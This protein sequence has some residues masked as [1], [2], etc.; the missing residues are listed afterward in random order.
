MAVRRQKVHVVSV[1]F[2]QAEYDAITK[3]C[4]AEEARSLSEFARTAMKERLAA[5]EPEGSQLEDDE[6]ALTQRL[7]RVYQELRST[8]ESVAA[9][10]GLTKQ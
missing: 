2:T 8:T 7:E 3:A 6:N 9:M 1:R 10:L 4:E 5:R